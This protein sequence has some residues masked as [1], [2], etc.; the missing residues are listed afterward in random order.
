MPILRENKNTMNELSRRTRV[1]HRHMNRSYV[2][3][4][5]AQQ[6]TVRKCQLVS[7]G[8]L[9]A[10]YMRGVTAGLYERTVI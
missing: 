9:V 6:Q 3:F 8:G 4:E 10:G 5:I 1:I 2:I 7:I